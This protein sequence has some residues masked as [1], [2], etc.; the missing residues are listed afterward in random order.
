MEQANAIIPPPKSGMCPQGCG[1]ELYFKSAVEKSADGK[2]IKTRIYYCK[3]GYKAKGIIDLA[4]KRIVS[5]LEPSE[6]DMQRISI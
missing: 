2:T 6:E 4:R 5:W 3:C 1:S